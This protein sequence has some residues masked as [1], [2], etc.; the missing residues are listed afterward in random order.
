M[1]TRLHNCE[2]IF[3]ENLKSIKIDKDMMIKFNVFSDLAEIFKLKN[4]D[5][6]NEEL[7]KMFEN[8][9][10][11]LKK[12]L[13]KFKSDYEIEINT[14]KDFDNNLNLIFKDLNRTTIDIMKIHFY[15]IYEI[16]FFNSFVSNGLFEDKDISNKP[17][18]LQWILGKLNYDYNN[19]NNPSKLKKQKPITCE[20][21]ENE[22]VTK[23]L[24]DIQQLFGNELNFQ[25]YFYSANQKIN[26]SVD[27]GKFKFEAVKPINFD[28]EYKKRY[29]LE[30]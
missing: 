2:T 7:K 12:Y 9:K 20:Y 29:V 28:D 23:Q 22:N 8:K 6:I 16:R 18:D 17:I 3:K 14:S 1:Y 4:T 15:N 19:E 25:G 13:E 11:Y 10:P 21:V 24:K 5:D 26:K 27:I 30:K